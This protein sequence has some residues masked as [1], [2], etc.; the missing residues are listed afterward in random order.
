M[1]Q[2]YISQSNISLI[3]NIQNINTWADVSH[4]VLKRHVGDTAGNLY[5]PRQAV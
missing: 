4:I 2:I 5:S 1:Y 3:L